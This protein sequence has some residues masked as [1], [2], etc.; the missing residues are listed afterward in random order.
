MKRKTLIVATLILLG[1]MARAQDEGSVLKLDLQ[2]AIDY[3]M[4]HNKN[5]E[6]ARQELIKSDKSVWEAISQGLPQVDASLDY[7]TN[8][9]FEMEFPSFIPGGEPTKFELGDQM[10][11]KMQLSQLVFSGQYIV[12]IQ[13]AKLAKIISEQA[14]DNSE[15]STKESVINAYYLVLI[16]ESSLKMVK[17]NMENLDKILNQTEKMYEAGMAEHI[18][19]DQFQVNVNQLSNTIRSMNRNLEITYNMLRFTLGIPAGSEII[20]TDDLESLFNDKEASD[21]LANEFNKESNI[22]YQILSSQAAI[23]KKLWDMQ[24]WN[25][26]PT[27]AGFAS[28]T[29][30]IKTS[31]F[32]MNPP[33]MAGFSLS[34]PIFSS[35]MRDA[36]V[37]QARIDYEIAERNVE[38]LGDQLELQEN[39]LKYDLQNSLEN[40]YTQ[41]EN[42][43][44]AR[45]VLDNYEQKYKHGMASSM[46]VTQANSSFL[47][48]QSSFLSAMFEV[49]NAQIQL[50]KLM[51]NLSTL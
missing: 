39:Q 38:I 48:A 45:R 50:E 23:N 41:K 49:M 16:S 47:D 28:A 37:G 43:D 36:K 1:S 3:A 11:A 2:G 51:N 29:Y 27:L 10:T 7:M 46:E 17:E 31:S 8:F 9:G 32:D 15:I 13:T 20:L 21:L 24:K 25:Y 18:D 33:F 12:G 30:K 34:L 26:G 14:L 22:G 44:V 35:G 4:Q 5:L 19:V 6:N 40:Y 42:V